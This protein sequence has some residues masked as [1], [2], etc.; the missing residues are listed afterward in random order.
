MQCT[1]TSLGCKNVQNLRKR[2]VF[3]HVHRKKNKKRMQ[4]P[5]AGTQLSI[6]GRRVPHGFQNV[7][8]REL[9]FLEKWGSLID[10]EN[11]KKIA[12]KKRKIQKKKRTNKHTKNKQIHILYLCILGY[13]PTLTPCRTTYLKGQR[14]WRPYLRVSCWKNMQIVRGY[15]PWNYTR[16]HC[17][18]DTN[19]SVVEVLRSHSWHQ[20]GWSGGIQIP[21]LTPMLVW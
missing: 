19:A 20:C 1:H 10:P 14:K 13:V 4:K 8:S 15:P 18:P 21:L 7:G 11:L 6:F 3:G 17:T 5:R 12:K 16:S 9:I 2:C